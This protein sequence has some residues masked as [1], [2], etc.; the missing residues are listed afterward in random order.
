MNDTTHH[1]LIAEVIRHIAEQ[2]AKR[3][4]FDG[5]G[6]TQEEFVTEYGEVGLQYWREAPHYECLSDLLREWG[7]SAWRRRSYGTEEARN[8]YIGEFGVLFP[9]LLLLINVA[10]LHGKLKPSR[11]AP[12]S[13]SSTEVWDHGL[14]IGVINYGRKGIVHVADFRQDA[15]EC[16]ELTALGGWKW[17]KAAEDFFN[18]L[19]GYSRSGSE[20]N[21]IIKF[22]CV[23]V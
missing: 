21:P 2:K 20:E 10:H 11:L 4:G 15:Y 5:K 19:D 7:L 17:G 1:P 6:Y 13:W 12:E 23:Q 8:A 18:F 3:I 16:Q 14:V 22:L 9:G